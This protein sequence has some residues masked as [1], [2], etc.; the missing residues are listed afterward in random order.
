MY[1][2]GDVK[3]D[4]NSYDAREDPGSDYNSAEDP[5]LVA[6]LPHSCDSW[7][8]GG[9]EQIEQMIRDLKAAHALLLE[10]LFPLE[11]K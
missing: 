5:A 9:P 2:P 4:V 1:H 10:K 11:E 7:I 3:V 6:Y 8:I